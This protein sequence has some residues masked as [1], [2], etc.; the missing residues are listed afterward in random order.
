MMLTNG[1]S[2]INELLSMNSTGLHKSTNVPT[3]AA[4]GRI[5]IS[6]SVK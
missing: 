5:S 4:S 2:V 6:R 1:T 3:A